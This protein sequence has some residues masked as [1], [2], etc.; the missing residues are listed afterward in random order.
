MA[1]GLHAISGRVL[2]LTNESFMR[3][4]ASKYKEKTMSNISNKLQ[5]LL[6]MPTNAILV[7]WVNAS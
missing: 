1:E 2:Q 6:H 7:G 3:G 5:S 4:G